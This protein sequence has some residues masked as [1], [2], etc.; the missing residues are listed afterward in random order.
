MNYLRSTHVIVLLGPYSLGAPQ[1]RPEGS[2]VKCCLS[3]EEGMGEGKRELS[4]ISEEQA[5]CSLCLDNEK[6]KKEKKN[7]V[8]SMILII[9]LRGVDSTPTRG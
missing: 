4:L 1:K 8:L 7:S 5:E 9:G 6:E 3:L 2:W